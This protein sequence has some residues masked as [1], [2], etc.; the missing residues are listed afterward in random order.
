MR[1]AVARDPAFNFIYRENLDRLAE[2]GN[3]TFSVPFMA[4]ICRMRIWY[5]FRADI[6]NCLPASCI[7]G[8]G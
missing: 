8:N 1:I 4:V 6:R 2:S 7:A 3:L 5:T